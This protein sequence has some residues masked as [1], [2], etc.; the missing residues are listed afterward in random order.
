M[1]GYV[2]V[3]LIDIIVAKINTYNTFSLHFTPAKRVE[4]YKNSKNNK[5][6]SEGT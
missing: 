6:K 2:A 3:M 4:K 1:L 5:I